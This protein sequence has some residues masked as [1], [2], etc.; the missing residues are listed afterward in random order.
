ML[1]RLSIDKKCGWCV[2]GIYLFFENPCNNS[3]LAFH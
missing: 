1:D 3:R 2:D